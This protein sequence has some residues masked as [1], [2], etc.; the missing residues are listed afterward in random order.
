MTP[1]DTGQ[2]AHR[3]RRSERRQGPFQPREYVRHIL[4]PEADTLTRNLPYG[5]Q[6]LVEIALA[7]AT[8]PGILLLDA[9]RQRDYPVITGVFVVFAVLVVFVNLLIDLVSPLIDPRLTTEVRLAA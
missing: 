9:V 7:L 2:I 1:W 6:R 3:R 4:A 5:K 8:K